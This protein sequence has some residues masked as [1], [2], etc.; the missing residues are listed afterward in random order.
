M[1]LR[2]YNTD[3]QIAF[4]AKNRT[5]TTRNKHTKEL[6]RLGIHKHSQTLLFTPIKGNTSSSKLNC[7]QNYQNI[8]KVVMEG[9]KQQ[10]MLFPK[11]EINVLHI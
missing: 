4:L 6:M 11:W 2:E 10:K 7:E 3:E 5:K 9:P 1:E 8:T